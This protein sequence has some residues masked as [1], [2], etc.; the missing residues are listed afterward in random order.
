MPWKKKVENWRGI[1]R[2]EQSRAK[3]PL[4]EDLVLATIHV[5]S[6]GH[7]GS[8][9]Q[10][11]GASGLMQVMPNTLKWYNQQTGDNITLEQLRS[12]DHGREQIRVG[13]WVLHQFWRG[14]HRY[15]TGRLTDIPVDELGRIADLFYVAGP[16]AAKKRLDKVEIPFY[17]YVAAKFPKWNALPHPR[18][19]WAV[20]PPDTVWNTE[21]ISKWLK[22]SVKQIKQT[23]NNVLLLIAVIA[24]GYWYFMRK[25]KTDDKGKKEKPGTG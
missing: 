17:S 20:L 3:S 19:V 5:E 16:A 9:N 11:S 1:V 4:P 18:N 10:K 15:L 14:A 23:R 13:L 22:G 8:T 6:R 24:I 2:E 12:K 21:A 25:G 7:P